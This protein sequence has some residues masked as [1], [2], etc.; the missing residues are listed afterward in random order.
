M[1]GGAR[2]SIHDP[3]VRAP[4]PSEGGRR[5]PPATH[6]DLPLSRDLGA[7]Q[8]LPE[9]RP[10][11]ALSRALVCC[12]GLPLC[13]DLSPHLWMWLEPVGGGSGRDHLPGIRAGPCHQR[14]LSDASGAERGGSWQ[15]LR[16]G[17]PGPVTQHSGMPLHLPGIKDSGVSGL[18]LSVVSVCLLLPISHIFSYALVM[19]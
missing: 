12:G 7:G 11:P 10:G 14:V 16:L 3:A 13:S 2:H 17:R 19:C 5:L 15:C 8:D 1:G 9:H 18:F 6:A 4:E